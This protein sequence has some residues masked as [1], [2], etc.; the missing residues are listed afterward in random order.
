MDDAFPRLVQRYLPAQRL[1]HWI[2]VASFVALL[3]SGF[4]LLVPPFAFLAAGGLS[5][6]IHRVAAIPFVAL[7]IVYAVVLPRETLE[8]LRESFTYPR[9]DWEWFKRMPAYVLGRTGGLPP[10]G[11]LNPGQ[12]LHHAGTFLMFLT[13]SGSGCAL[14]IGSGRLGANGLAAV[15]MVHDLS[16][17][18]LTVLL[19]GHVYF[20]FLYDAFSAM[21][22][23]FVTEEY[24]RM[25][26]G[27]WVEALPVEA[28]AGEPARSKVANP[29]EKDTTPP[30]GVRPGTQPSQTNRHER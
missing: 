15:A 28:F 21:G 10:Q 5:R 17:L 25:E 2:G 23:G 1:I 8:L 20:T 3:L 11:R 4:A 18:G 12:R 6:L 30:A 9:E 22:T 27:R 26:H 13:I 16:L 19:I 14:W 7:P 24:A 29:A